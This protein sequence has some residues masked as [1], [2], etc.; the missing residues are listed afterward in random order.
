MLTT[1]NRSHCGTS[2]TN[3]L[4]YS[5]N[6]HLHLRREQLSFIIFVTLLVSKHT[7]TS[8]FSR[9]PDEK[10]VEGEGKGERF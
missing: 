8:E 9:T 2:F 5:M 10:D 7:S 3:S 1:T 6:A 4:N